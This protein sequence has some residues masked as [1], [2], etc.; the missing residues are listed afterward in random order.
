M[1]KEKNIIPLFFSVDD[2]YAKLLTISLHSII[3]NASTK[4]HYEVIVLNTGL[5]EKSIS[6]IKSLENNK[7]SISFVNVCENLDRISS[8]LLTRDY[9][10]KTTYYRLFIASLFPQF[11]KILYLDSDTIING[12][13]SELYRT[14][15]GSN[16][17]GAIPDA[18]VQ[19]VPEFIEY[20][21]KALGIKHE[22]YFNAGILLM[23]LKKMRDIDFEEHFINL[24][25]KY[26]FEV[27]QDQYY[28]NVLCHEDVYFIDESWNT[29]PL[30]E[31]IENPNLI[32]FNL[33]FKPWKYDDIMYEEYFYQN[34]KEIS[35][36]KDILEMK[37][38][39]KEE[40]KRID[41]LGGEKIKELC[42]KE[43]ND[44]KN[45]YHLFVEDVHINIIKKILKKIVS[46]FKNAIS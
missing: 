5:N 11:D 29:M 3:K 41:L 17:V 21:E 38:S 37:A 15:I 16:L 22:D 27:A 2:N 42:L 34:V 12:D 31:K 43:A 1:K 33:T 19:I 30:G 36:E 25:K 14:D 35:L 46:T 44:E 23:N 4:Y 10:T 32:H 28:L 13:I 40:M 45:Y 24:L 18:S 39:F 8:E 6:L 9:Y 20:V 7:F 26:K